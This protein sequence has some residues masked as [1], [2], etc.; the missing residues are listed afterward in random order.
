[1]QKY[2][3]LFCS[4]LHAY[5][6]IIVNQ[7]QY[8]KH[9]SCFCIVFRHFKNVIHKYHQMLFRS[10]CAFYM[11]IFQ[12]IHFLN[13]SDQESQL[14]KPGSF[15]SVSG[16]QKTFQRIILFFHRAAAQFIVHGNCHGFQHGFR[17]FSFHDTQQFQFFTA[18]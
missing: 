8:S 14:T 1:M 5:Y 15:V 13:H 3:A 10:F 12:K 6:I 11:I 9:F 18:G 2:H 4:S 17:H 7:S 16:F